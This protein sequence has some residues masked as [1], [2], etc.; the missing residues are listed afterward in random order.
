MKICLLCEGSYPYIVGG[1]SAWV[2]QLIR[3]FPE[4]EFC[5]YTISAERK[6]TGKFAYEF[7]VNVTGHTEVFLDDVYSQKASG[8]VPDVSG[9]EV[10]EIRK[11]IL[12]DPDKWE[13]IFNFFSR[14][15]RVVTDF[16]MSSYF[17]DIAMGV[18]EKSYNKSI[19]VDFIWTLRSMYLTLFHVLTFPPPKADLYHSVSTGYAGVAASLGKYLYGSSYILTEH[20]IYT[21]EREEEIIKADWVSGIYKNL[22]IDYFK[23]MSRCAYK[24]ADKAIALYEMNSRI[25]IELGL[26]K[27]KAMVIANGI[28]TGDFENLTPKDPD[29]TGMNVG[30]VIRVTPIKDIKTMLYAFD[31]VKR[32]RPDTKFFIMGPDDEAPEYY[33]E[34]LDILKDLGTRDVVF[35]GRVNVREYLG[36][37][38]VVVLTSIS[39]AQ[40]LALME[41]MSAGKPCVSTNVGCCFELFHGKSGDRLGTAGILAPV[42]NFGKIAEAIIAL[43]DDEELRRTYGSNARERIRRYYTE[44]Q[45]KAAYADLYRGFEPERYGGV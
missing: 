24:Y 20:G 8:T 18:Y 16:L 40:P 11:L 32:K 2:H 27:E 1:V 33:R 17:Y 37:M 45:F 41:A 5:L 28:K 31:A 30:A 6:Q 34:C 43:L 42:M 44:E 14:S 36:K 12:S 15:G 39:E 25:Q 35:T 21:R 7:P 19:Y 26:E 4:Y 13:Y 3:N 23:S 10:E 9:W 22:W 29:D 38:D